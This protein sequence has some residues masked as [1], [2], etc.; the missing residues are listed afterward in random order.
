MTQEEEERD[1]RRR[2]RVERKLQE[3]QE[4]ERQG[5][6]KPDQQEHF[7]MIEFAET[8]FN[9]HERVPEG[10]RSGVCSLADRITA[11]TRGVLIL[12]RRLNG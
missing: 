7:D 10:E 11:P 9:M 3:L 8:Y 12:R 6:A 2:Q 4:L 1:L 5:D